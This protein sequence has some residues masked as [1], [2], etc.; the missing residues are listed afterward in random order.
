MSYCRVGENQPERN[1]ICE[2]CATNIP[3]M[4]KNVVFKHRH[5]VAML[6]KKTNIK[7]E[8]EKVRLNEFHLVI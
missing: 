6:T 4:A 2:Y 5:Q 8:G 7:H 1:K 3:P